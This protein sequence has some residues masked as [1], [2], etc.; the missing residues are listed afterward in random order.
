VIALAPPFRRATPADAAALAEFVNMA[1]EGMPLYLWRGMTKAGEDPWE[2]GR[3]RA[4]RE[5]GSFSYRNAAMLEEDGRAIGCLIGYPLPDEPVPIDRS[6]MPAMFVALQELE[7]LAPCAWYVNVLAVDPEERGKG[8]GARLLALAEEI[9]SA[10]RSRG[11]AIIVA[12]SNTGAWRLYERHG[13]R[14]A[15]KRP[16]V[17]E[18]W[19]SPGENWVLLIKGR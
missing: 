18:G 8:H 4:R 5:S 17:K 13:Y 9:A 3:Q 7:D 14:K 6:K 15:A 2:I 16:M 19:E 12:D 10:E 1:G 11:L